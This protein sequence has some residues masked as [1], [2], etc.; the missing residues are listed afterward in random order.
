MICDRKPDLMLFTEVIPK[1]QQ[2]PIHETQ[3]K[4]EGYQHFPNFNFTDSNLGASGIRGVIVYVKNN[5]SC[6]E[7]KAK[8]TY[9]DHVWVELSL[10]KGDSLLCGCVY[11]SP[12]KDRENTKRTTD[13]VSKVLR[14]MTRL[15]KPTLV[16][17]DFNY[18]EIDWESEYVKESSVTIAPFIEAVQESHLHQHIYKPTRYR[19]GNEPS[20]LDLIFTTEEG[21]IRELH[22]K[23]GLGESDHE[24]VDFL[25]NLSQPT[26]TISTK[27]NFFKADY[28]TIR[29]RLREIEWEDELEGC[30][31]EAYGK[32]VDILTESMIG[33][34][35]KS[36]KPK[37]HSTNLYFTIEAV[38]KKDLK[39]KLWKRYRKSRCDY[40]FNRYKRAKNDLRVLT[41]RLRESFEANIVGDLKSAP[42]KFWSYVKSKTKVRNK[43]PTLKKLDG[44]LAVGAKEK[45]EALNDFFCTMFTEENLSTL[46]IV[47]EDDYTGEQIDSFSILPETVLKKLQD[48]NP[49]KSPGPDGWH[50]VFLKAIADLIAQPLALLFQK[51]LEE[52]Y[53]PSEWRSACITALHKKEAKDVCGNYRPV[54]ITSI[55]C[56]LMESIVRDQIVN[57]MQ[58][59]KLFSNKQHGFVPDRN[60]MTNLLT[61]LE[62]WTDMMEKGLPIDI[63]YTD[64]AKAFDRVPHQRLLLKLKL[65]G[66]TGKTLSWIKAFLSERQQCVRVENECSTWKKVISGIPQGSVLGPILFVVFIN[67]MPEAVS[68]M[69]QLFADDAKIF[70]GIQSKEDIAA[71]Q[72]DLDRLDEWSD[73]W[74][75]AF[76]V[77]KC[78]SL[79]IGS[80][81]THHKYKMSGKGL[82]HIE[83]EKDL[84]VLIDEKLDFHRQAAAAVKKANRVLGL[85]KRTF[86]N[87]D[88]VTLPL[89]YTSL[90]RS[91]LEYGNV[92]WGPFY[93]ADIIAVEKIQR[94]AT[95]MI[96]GLSQLS[97]E[98]RLQ[99]LKLPSLLHRRRR[100]DMIQMYKITQGAVD[101]EK[102]L[103]VN[104]QETAT[105]GH[106][107]KLRKTKA[108][109]LPRIRAFSNRVIDEWN[110]LPSKVVN[111]PSIN[112]FKEE[113]DR[114]WQHR[115][116]DTPF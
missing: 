15:R 25:L 101:V 116:Y 49:G 59:N 77:D 17:G 67:D 68:S 38:R 13:D 72:E 56:K 102:K 5:I 2:N 74:Q 40:D 55:I 80:R 106:N 70:R 28:T 1:A 104:S 84:G 113:L 22:H 115:M 62:L 61:C 85:V 103:F 36:G 19:S 114:H 57:H 88:A 73:K 105:R 99:E 97:Y 34:V 91:L 65:L 63:I 83:E 95:K 32:F 82:E 37:K 90:V 64:F 71:L 7:V 16:C 24:C 35:P 9:K 60:C 54:S 111:A 8:T 94:R 107:L 96:R 26:E 52:G 79:H 6:K 110:Q 100:G 21:M 39:N 66:I 11:R 75:L 29:D 81:N 93:K 51:S 4:I 42:K 98:E 43:I 12:T 30:F 14:D 33:C 78:K 47:S 31:S 18:P 53:V 46:P 69:C 50:P 58:T 23:P 41:R 76:N 109:I 108:T 89:L 45:A 48:L 92:I 10:G 112:S 86:L 87:L 3:I 20:L 27:M 44:S